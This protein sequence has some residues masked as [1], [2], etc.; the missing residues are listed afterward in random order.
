MAVQRGPGGDASA[1]GNE[2]GASS[3]SGPA[4]TAVECR[5]QGS[6]VRV[7]IFGDDD[8]FVWHAQASSEGGSVP[9]SAGCRHDHVDVI[10][11]Q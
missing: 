2:K 7:L 11:L 6:R 1:C 10:Q 5:R 9:W 3:E 8:L 4:Y